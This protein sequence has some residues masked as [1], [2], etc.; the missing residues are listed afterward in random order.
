MLRKPSE[1]IELHQSL[2]QADL[3]LWRK[4]SRASL[5]RHNDI[6]NMAIREFHDT[7]KN[8]VESLEYLV[9]VSSIFSRYL[10][11]FFIFS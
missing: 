1:P 8:F 2:L 6:R 11:R 9:Q 4:R 5:R 10:F 3:L 7:E